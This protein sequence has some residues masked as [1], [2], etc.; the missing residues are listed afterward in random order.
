MS[1]FSE[2]LKFLRRKRRLTLDQLAQ[3]CGLS[4]GYISKLERDMSEP[5]ISSVMK[6]GKALGV[7]VGR[8][9]GDVPDE[10]QLCL[11]RHDERHR[12]AQKTG[13][14]GHAFEA[15]AAKRPMKRMEP[16]IMRPLMHLP[17]PIDLSQ[18][19]GEEFM[20]VISG[21]AEIRILDHTITLSRGD[22]L[23]FDA[24][25]PHKARSIGKIPAEILVV[26]AE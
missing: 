20:H 21:K 5:T 1:A 3:L 23:Y 25:I 17:E 6:L 24:T 22:S 9:L 13:K 8:L 26:I 19:S 15:L 7:G 4:K 11:V 16:F 14:P 12:H 10:E 2:R 18:H